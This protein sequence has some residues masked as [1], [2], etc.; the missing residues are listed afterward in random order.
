M[1]PILYRGTS[2]HDECTA[3]IFAFDA[4]TYPW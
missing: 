2:E 3:V 4:Q 1:T